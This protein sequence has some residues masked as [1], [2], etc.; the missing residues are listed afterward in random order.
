MTRR[1]TWLGVE[2]S[3]LTKRFG[4]TVAVDGLSFTAQPGRVTGFLGPN[5]AGKTTSLRALVGLVSPTS[6]TATIGGVAY[7]DLDAPAATVGAVLESS[8]FHPG[9]TAR[10]HLRV[11]AIPAGI[12]DARVDEVLALVGLGDAVS[13]KAGGFS[14]GMRQR[15]ALAAA[16]LGDPAVLLLDEPAN[17]LDPE[18]IRWLRELLRAAAAQ[19]RT[20]LVSSHV[21]GEVEHTVDDVVI[22]NHGRLVLQAPLADVTSRLRAVRVRTPDASRLSEALTARGATV[23]AAHDG[24]L[25][26]RGIVAAEVG[27][28]AAAARVVLH[29]L[30]DEAGDLESAFFALTASGDRAGGRS[31][32]SKDP[33]WAVPAAR[34]E[35]R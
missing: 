26:V 12:T 7:R 14:L 5:G 22:I 15:L 9:R 10:D 8:G 20:V 35:S 11:L 3:G 30:V 28:V 24:V 29:Q 21:L 1:A 33:L 13:R 6:G 18:G 19:G 27:E 2:V 34:K 31:V 16:L 32:S 23:E 25:R 4:S 17:G